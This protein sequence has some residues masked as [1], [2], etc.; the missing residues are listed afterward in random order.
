[1]KASCNSEEVT[2]K[3]SVRLFANKWAIMAKAPAAPQMDGN[4]EE[5][6]WGQSAEIDGFVTAFHNE[7]V[8]R[9]TR[10]RLMVDTEQLYIA[11]E[12]EQGCETAVDAESV[13]VLLGTPSDKDIYY[14]I[15]VDVTKGRHPYAIGYNN[16][17]GAELRDRRQKFVHLGKEEGVRTVV[18]KRADGSWSAEISV[19]LVSLGEP[20]LRSGAEWR[21]N[22]IRYFGPDATEPLSSWVPIRTGTIRMEDVRRPLEERLFRLELYVANEGR[23]GT[24]FVERPSGNPP[25]VRT[26]TEWKLSTTLATLLY[27]GNSEKTL[28]FRSRD[29]SGVDPSHLSIAWIDP[30]GRKTVLDSTNLRHKEA[31]YTLDFVHPDAREDGLYQIRLILGEGAVQSRFAA[32]V[33]DRYDLIAAGE[34]TVRPSPSDRPKRT[35]ALVPPSEEV[36]FLERLIPDRIGFFGAGVPHRPM[37]GF[38]STNYT[39]SPEAPW[40]IISGDDARVPYPNDRYPE[41][42]AILVTNKRGEVVEYPYFEDEQGMRYFL[43]AHLWHYQRKHAIGETG[44]L[45]GTDPL[46]AARLLHKFA[47]AYAGWVRFNDSVWVQHPIG[48]SAHPPY[49][50]FGGMWDRWNLMD[51]HG[52][53]PLLDA[54]IEVDQTNAFELLSMEAGVD[55]RSAIVDGMLHPS[56]ESVVT[57]PVLQSNVDFPNWIGLIQ[58]GKALGE[59][60]LV[61]EAVERL[62]RFVKSC[63]LA[64]GFWKEITLSYH[65]QTCYG[66]SQTIRCLDGYSDPAGY[67][68]PR[69][70]QRY[71]MF[72]AGAWVPLMDSLLQ[73][74][75]ILAYP[76]GKCF[77]VNDTWASQ[78]AANPQCTGSVVL[79]SAGIAKLT[80]GLG[81][82]Q[83]QLYLTFS[84][85]NG[86]D[87][88]DPLN[89]ALYAEGQE[90]LP[91]IGYTHTFY[92]QWSVSTLGHN[93]VT[94]NGQD[95]SLV[96]SAK[97]GGNIELFAEAANVQMI[98]A[99]QEC[100]YSDV[101]HYSRELLFIG[102][103]GAEAAEGYVVDLFRVSGGTRHEYALNGD[104]NRDSEMT[105]NIALTDYGPYLVEGRPDIIEPKQETDYGGTSDNQYYAYAYVK[106]VRTAE[107]PDGVYNMTL[108]TCDNNGEPSTG[109]GLKVHGFAGPGHNRLFQGRAPS[110]RSTRLNGLEGDR[111][112]EAILYSMPK[113]IVRREAPDG[114]DLHSQFVHVM[115]PY[116]SDAYPAIERVEV[117]RSDETTNEVV[118][119]V[120]YG[121]VTDIIMSAPYYNGK[122][123]R[124]GK[125]E[126]AGKAGFIRLKDGEVSQMMLVGGTSLT[127]GNRTLIGEGPV[128]GRIMD[129]LR[130]VS[131][132]GKHAFLTDANIPSSV[133]GCYAVIVHP[134]HTTAAYPVVSVTRDPETGL[135]ELGFAVDL[136]FVYTDSPCGPGSEAERSSGMTAYPET[137]WIG[138][139]TFYI[140]NVELCYG[141]ISPGV[142]PQYLR[143]TRMK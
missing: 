26:P 141:F 12:S 67:V 21:L 27:R 124:A 97:N 117:I 90:L 73:L 92:R 19:P 104:A 64:D 86:H 111:N 75:N 80:R 44:R 42:K 105:T 11:L 103:E 136:G 126:L 51:L 30:L 88:K 6:E 31:E 62:L 61:H 78:K 16:W 22:V 43:S 131:I 140:D 93:T 32:F 39:W 56:V 65:Q 34:R 106:E 91:D 35:I 118:V 122:P 52:L 87:H 53:L 94:V 99:R 47:R 139:H 1:M 18:S 138:T 134:D 107:L 70:G 37:L 74:Q 40:L 69:D 120:S 96:G 13:F 60:R 77:P 98:R 130:P 84:P 143:N 20:D 23:L 57:Y 15:S 101:S 112:S 133:I 48:G 95:A 3:A 119:T 36:L 59:P 125:W 83:A 81:R 115:E 113:W 82:E 50:Y 2:E 14:S 76:D 41:S 110:L 135:T 28:S 29:L 71:D 128:A 5:S 121:S 17:T 108:T 45:V 72:D 24:V 10:V 127:A 66:L 54:F 4:I 8:K 58:T 100:A 46:G 7:P 49:P 25:G 129:V 137:E 132:G 33:F 55:I 114:A 102:F 123:L 89:L 142:T 85:N 38:R 116:A 68:S 63:Y 109:A 9:D 79:P